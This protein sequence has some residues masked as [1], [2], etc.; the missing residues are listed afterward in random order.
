MLVQSGRTI[1][2]IT[3]RELRST[4]EHEL[5]HP[6]MKQVWG[7][8]FVVPSHLSYKMAKYGGVVLGA[9]SDHEMIG[10]VLSFPMYHNYL[11]GLYSHLNGVLP[12]YQGFRVG[13]RLKLAQ[14]VAA[15]ARGHRMITWTYDPLESPNARLNIGLLGAICNEYMPNYYGVMTDSRNRGIETDR[16]QVQ[17]WLETPRAAVLLEQYQRGIDLRDMTAAGL[18]ATEIAEDGDVINDVH[19]RPDGLLESEAPRLDLRSR[20]LLLRIP[21]SFQE[22]K[23]RNKTLAIDWRSVT[24]SAFSSYFA[25][26]W[27]ATGFLP[28]ESYNTYVLQK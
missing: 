4:A 19:L 1:S 11:H 23:H 13:F 17:W 16:F 15:L 21:K 27:T 20:E 3:I 2:D 14:G 10:F 6:I 25:R 28:A 18:Q 7:P 22:M 9:F 5:M 12:E 26:G 8:E 24:R